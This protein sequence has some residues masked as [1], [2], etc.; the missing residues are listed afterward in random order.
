M[1]G[2]GGGHIV[3]LSSV[4]GRT[5][6]LGAAVYNLTKWGVV[7]FS[8]GLRQEALHAN[9]RVTVVEP[10]FVDT[11]LQGHNEHP[12]V[13]EAIEK[14]RKDLGDDVLVPADIADAIVY[15][16]SSPPRVAINE[17]VEIAHAFYDQGEP[18]FINS[19]LDRVARQVRPAELV[20]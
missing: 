10:G 13:V 16:L 19:V 7:G 4:A 17:Y 12:M 11:E 9:I 18:N 15:A 5:A 6:S 1:G 8:E 2:S 14:M 3:N 20:K